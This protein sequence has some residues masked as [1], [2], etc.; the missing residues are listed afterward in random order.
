MDPKI[1]IY[2]FKGEI[3]MKSSNRK[4]WVLLII[5][6]VLMIFGSLLGSWVMKGAGAATL[7]EIKFRGHNG[8]VISAYLW[9]P[10]SATAQ[11]PAPGVLA[12]H[13]ADNSKEFM[14]NSAIELARRGYVVLS[15][16]SAGAGYSDWD[17]ADNTQDCLNY[18]KSL[19]TV[20]PSNIGMVGM[21][22]GGIYLSGVA[23]ST[24][25]YN[26]IYLM[27]S[28]CIMPAL[29]APLKNV[30]LQWSL[31][32][33]MSIFGAE[34]GRD[35]PDSPALQ[36]VFGTTEK[37]KVG[38][39]Y[40]SIADGTARILYQPSGEHA[41]SHDDPQTMRNLI[42]WFGMTLEGENA[43]VGTNLIFQWKVLGTSLALIGAVL[44]LFPA[45][46]LLLTTPFYKP[47]VEKVP[48]YKGLK[49]IGWWI[50]AVITAALGA[51]L[52]NWSYVKSA[53]VIPANSL[54]PQGLTNG[55]ML[56]AV[57]IG[58]IDVLLI[59]L[60]HFAFTKKQGATA[61]NYGLT[62]EGKGLEWGKIAKSFLLAVSVLGVVYLIL[63]FTNSVWK[64]DFRFWIW[65]L[66][67]MSPARFQA[68]LG[69]L[70]PFAVLFIPQGILF[71]GFLRVNNGKVTIGRE[72]LV[73]AA[74][75]VAGTVA[76]ILW[77]YIPIF[78]GLPSPNPDFKSLFFVPFLLILPLVACL[79]TFFF[80]KTGRVYTGIFFVTIFVV[81]YMAAF[82][83]FSFLP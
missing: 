60:N 6:L 31:A 73:N 10:N 49:G 1:R 16:D 50:A 66:K 35:L 13:G 77:Y 81:W 33:E 38:E 48:E 76:L 63:L 69:Y 20:D 80:R 52:W 29:C 12:V 51:L 68:F 21:S 45:G 36:E 83:S 26:S 19:N 40:G 82:S 78:S 79:Y 22:L 5:A 75:Y 56:W 54:W 37:I 59:L 53:T 30:A 65:A 71:A 55:H 25:D 14:A 43:T 74:V 64:V 62:S 67:P 70:I 58:V 23:R 57:I 18:L 72:M 24:E 34:T 28:T 42:E 47:L 39:T 27:E 17:T 9:T 44:F 61:A 4:H 32:E 7:K 15:I 11:T 8:N 2:K 46:A 41:M 3:L